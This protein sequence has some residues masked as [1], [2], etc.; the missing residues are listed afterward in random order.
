MKSVTIKIPDGFKIQLVKSQSKF[1]KGDVIVD[2]HSGVMAIYEKTDFNPIHTGIV[3][4][5]SLLFSK[6]EN[7]ITKMDFIDYGIGNEDNCRLATPEEKQ[8]IINALIE[9]EKK[10]RDEIAK[11]FLKDVFNI[12]LDILKIKTYQDLIDNKYAINGF[13]INR[14]SNIDSVFGI[15][16][17]SDRSIASSEKAAKSMLALAMISQL[18]LYYGGEITQKEWKNANMAKYIIKRENNEIGFNIY[19]TLYSF[20]AFHTP[21]QRSEFLNYNYQLV[22][23]YLMI[24]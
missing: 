19:Y 10:D 5:Y 9:K 2:N 22:K 1:K 20:L 17:A 21:E 16:C 7:K 12:E 15:A 3:I 18:L 14:N 24:D 8:L 4:Y 11:R 6:I 23:D 13:K